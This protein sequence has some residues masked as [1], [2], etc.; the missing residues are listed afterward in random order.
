MYGF[1]DGVR[2]L[3][4]TKTHD[5]QIRFLIYLLEQASRIADQR[6][7]QHTHTHTYTHT[8]PSCVA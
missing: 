4:N 2:R 6:G 7:A 3:E 1:H 8:Q 5:R